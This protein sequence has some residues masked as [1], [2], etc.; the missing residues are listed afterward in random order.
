MAGPGFVDGLKRTGQILLLIGFV[1]AL[2]PLVVT[3][4]FGRFVLKMNPV[5][6][7]GPCAGAS[8]TT[9]SLRAIQDAA[10]SKVPVLAY[11]VPYAIGAIV[12][13]ACGPIIVLLTK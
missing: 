9:A 1:M 2:T 3:L 5:M 10:D 13:T 8:T 11:T 7:L 12:L 4:L 6:L